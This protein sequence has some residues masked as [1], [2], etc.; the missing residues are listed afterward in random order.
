MLHPAR[1]LLARQAQHRRHPLCR[2]LK[3]EAATVLDDVEIHGLQF[4][5]DG[6]EL[7]GRNTQLDTGA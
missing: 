5:R 7:V 4:L 6:G 3:A 1:A 2:H